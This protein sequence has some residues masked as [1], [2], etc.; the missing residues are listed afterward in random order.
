VIEPDDDYENPIGEQ[1]DADT[2]AELARENL[3]DRLTK[4]L[5]PIWP[6]T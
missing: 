3:I 5:E 2:C 4:I 6:F 1:L